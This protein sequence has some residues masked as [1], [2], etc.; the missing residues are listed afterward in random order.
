MRHAKAGTAPVC[1]LL[2]A[3]A[4][5]LAGSLMA[6][7]ADSQQARPQTGQSEFVA[8]AQPT[9]EAMLQ[10]IE[11]FMALSPGDRST[12]EVAQDKR[13]AI[14][15]TSK[16]SPNDLYWQELAR[17]G[18]MRRAPVPEGLTQAGLADRF[19]AWTTTRL[20]REK[21]PLLIRIANAGQES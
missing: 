10:L 2:A 5:L 18:W 12:L 9:Q 19:S 13:D 6:Q 7:A 15:L 17:W 3:A 16:G 14:L 4:V 1:Q 8:Q 20:G 21:I 11:G